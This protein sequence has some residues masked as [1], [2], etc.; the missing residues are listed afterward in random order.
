MAA[1][2]EAMAKPQRVE[3]GAVLTPLARPALTAVAPVQMPATATA[4][5]V[6]SE[7]V[8]A[9]QPVAWVAAATAGVDEAPRAAPAPSPG[10]SVPTLAATPVAAT[11]TVMATA[12]PQ[13]APPVA[14]DQPDWPQQLGEQIHWRLG[15]GLREARIEVSPRELGPVDVQLSMDERGLRV[16]LSASHAQ[17]RE[18]LLSELPR[19]RECL[20]Q[21]GV[22]LADAQV[23]RDHRGRDAPQQPQHAAHT[24]MPEDAV[25]AAAT[26]PSR[27]L[28]GTG[29]L[30]HY[31]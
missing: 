20:Q 2:G 31:A 3:Q 19:L 5:A 1:D 13:A 7:T 15:E 29:L 26:A 11:T 18:L 14:L 28:R 25:D 17:T 23:S 22:Q 4:A 16:Q 10:G 30:D 24:P 12:A 8:A 6:T 21:H 27:W 9:S